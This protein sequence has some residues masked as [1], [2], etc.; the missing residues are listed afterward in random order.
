MK[1]QLDVKKQETSVVFE[2]LAVRN[3]GGVLCAEIAPPP[4]N[5]LGPA[6]VQ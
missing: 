4:M 3:E 1:R 5:L 6:L 2:T